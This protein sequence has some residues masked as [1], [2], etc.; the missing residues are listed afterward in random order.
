MLVGRAPQSISDL[1][2]AAG[3]T[4]TAI[5][6]QLY[7]LIEAG[8]VE[9]RSEQSPN[10]GRPRHLY[11]AT[12]ASLMLFITSQRLLIPS[13]FRAVRNIGSEKT[14]RAVLKQVTHALAEHYQRKISA[15]KPD[16][17]L[18]KLADILND[19]GAVIETAEEKGRFVMVKRS[20]PLVGILEDKR[21]I[22]RID[23]D[24]MRAVVGRHVTRTACRHDGAPCCTFIVNG[25]K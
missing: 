25:K 20:C 14:L 9:R 19:E 10:R 12:E 13:V 23:L 21:A 5:T 24:V 8:L 16:S 11:T 4:R 6:G 2:K 15:T 17:R 22:C 1:T 3:V 7:Q 18:R